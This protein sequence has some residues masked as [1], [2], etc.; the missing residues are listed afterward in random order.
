MTMQRNL[1]LVLGK[2]KL[3]APAAGTDNPSALGD[4]A[5]AMS[6]KLRPTDSIYRLAPE[7]FGLV[8]PQNDTLNAKRIAVGLQEEMQSVRSK[9]GATFETSVHNYTDDLQNSHELGD[10]VKI[11]VP[12]KKE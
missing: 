2:A 12:V 4:A 9:H 8:L 3:A 7:F 1:S 6:R 10:I 5:K 11:I